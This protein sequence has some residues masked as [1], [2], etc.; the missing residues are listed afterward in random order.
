MMLARAHVT[1]PLRQLVRKPFSGLIFLCPTVL[2][3]LFF[4]TVSGCGNVDQ[5]PPPPP[6]DGKTPISIESVAESPDPKN[7]FEKLQL[8]KVQQEFQK[9][10]LSLVQR[11]NSTDTSKGFD[12]KE[13][14]KIFLD[15]SF[16]FKKY[17]DVMVKIAQ[18]QKETKLRCFSIMKSLILAVVIYDK[19]GNK[20][21]FKFDPQKLIE[22]N[23]IKESMPCPG[24]GEYSIFYKDGRR[25]FHCSIHGTLR[26]N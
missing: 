19:K 2:A 10:Y 16:A 21:M 1:I 18:D 26:Q 3:F 20:K 13:Q 5:P 12:V 15:Y 24:G 17:H 22:E 11:I 23:I 8:P 6:E 9:S 7:I 4:L 25:F 14:Q